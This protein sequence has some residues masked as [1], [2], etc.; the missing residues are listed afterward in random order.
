M[1]KQTYEDHVR[2]LQGLVLDNKTL[3][4]FKRVVMEIEEAPEVP[5]FTNQ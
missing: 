1:S 2:G 4:D 5:I 3:R